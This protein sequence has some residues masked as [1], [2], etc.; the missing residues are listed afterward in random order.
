MYTF[1]ISIAFFFLLSACIFGKRLKENQLIVKAIIISGSF[2]SIVVVN[3]IVGLQVPFTVVETREREL[4]GEVN[5]AIRLRE[6]DTT[7][8]LKGLIGYGLN[9][10]AEGDTTASRIYLNG[11]RDFSLMGNNRIVNLH[12]LN[13]NDTIPRWVLHKQRRIVKNNRWIS[14]LGLPRGNI[15]YYDIY[16]PNDSIHREI[17]SWIDPDKVPDFFKDEKISYYEN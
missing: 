7:I 2:L 12:F 5:S 14:S 11:W 17:V 1:L 9:I 16:L 6:L 3:G 10:S 8:R 13:E 15:K 4:S